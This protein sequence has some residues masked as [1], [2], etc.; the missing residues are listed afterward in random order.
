MKET[1]TTL[2]N[3]GGG[4]IVSVDGEK[5]VKL[6]NGLWASLVSGNMVEEQ[7]MI[8]A[9]RRKRINYEFM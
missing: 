4:T 9:E 6:S 2:K 1:K 5:F 3:A 7:N 8:G